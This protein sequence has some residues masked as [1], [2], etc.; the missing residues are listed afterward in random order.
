MWSR[1]QLLNIH[2]FPGLSHLAVMTSE[3]TAGYGKALRGPLRLEL[4]LG[5]NTLQSMLRFV[6]KD[7]FVYLFER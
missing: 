1:E 5:G 2:Q 3:D 7:V 4:L 6:F